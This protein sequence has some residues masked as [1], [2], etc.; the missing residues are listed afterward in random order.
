MAPKWQS[1]TAAAAAPADFPRAQRSLGSSGGA[2]M[3]ELRAAISG[4]EGASGFCDELLLIEDEVAEAEA[5]AVAEAAAEA[6]A[7]PD[8]QAD[9]SPDVPAAEEQASSSWRQSL[10]KTASAPSLGGSRSSRL[11][12]PLRRRPPFQKPRVDRYGFPAARLSRPLHGDKWD[13]N[14]HLNGC[15]NELKPRNMRQYFSRPQSR[16]ELKRELATSPVLKNT[17]SILSRLELPEVAP[18]KQPIT[19]ESGLPV[20]PERHVVGGI[21]LDRDSSPRV[22]NDRWHKGMSLLNDQCHPDHRAYFTQKSLFEKSP[23][24]SYR[25]YLDQEVAPGVWVPTEPRKKAQFPP[26]GAPL[27]GRSGTPIPGATL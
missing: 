24:Q 9:G 15:E 17:R 18:Q 16:G 13:E 8:G 7:V 20:C 11:Q 10:Q 14:H 26:L 19:A 12:S 23:S 22:W 25:R 6:A 3:R 4:E 27:R 1:D 21:M 2:T 5:E